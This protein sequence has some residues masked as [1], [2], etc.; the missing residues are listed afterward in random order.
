MTGMLEE[1][2]KRI[3]PHK[4]LGW[5][6][7]NEKFTRF[8][9]IK[10][11]WF[12]VFLHRLNAPHWHPQAHDHPWDFVTI[13]LWKGY[14]EKTPEGTFFRRPGTVLYRAAEFA[15][16]VITDGTAWSIVVT[17]RKKRDWKFVSL[18]SRKSN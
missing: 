14:Y 1:V 13:L 3:L 2:L 17:G 4:D 12:R 18:D 6:E 11:P 15:H 8:T 16:N 7:L 5:T 10:T 9:L